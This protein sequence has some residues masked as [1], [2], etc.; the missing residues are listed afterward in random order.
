MKLEKRARVVARSLLFA[1]TVWLFW[2]WCAT[3]W[4]SWEMDFSAS[5]AVA[6]IVLLLFV[7]FIGAWCLIRGTVGTRKRA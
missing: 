5:Q 6:F 4:E 2:R 7:V 3:N 1:A